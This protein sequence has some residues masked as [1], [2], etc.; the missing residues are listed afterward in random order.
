L[1]PP[2][3]AAVARRS[4]LV[5]YATATM[6]FAFL[7]FGPLI[8]VGTV[9]LLRPAPYAWLIQLPGFDR[10]RVPSRIWMLG[11]LCLAVAAG[12]GLA[13]LR[14]T[15]ARSRVLVCGLAIA[16][17]LVDGW[18]TEFPMYAV[19]SHWP[20]VERRDQPVPILELPLGPGQDAAATFR[21]MRHRRPVVN[22][23]SGYDPAFYAPLQAGLE[24]RDPEVVVALAS[25]GALDVVVDGAEDRDGRWAAYAAAIPGA[26]ATLSDGVRTVY[27]VVPTQSFDVAV[28]ES[29]PIAA[30]SVS[31]ETERAAAAIDRRMETQWENGPQQPGQWIAVDLG[32]VRDVAGVTHALGEFARDFPRALAIDASI[33]GTTWNEVLNERT[34]ALA[35]LGAIREPTAAVM[36]FSFAPRQARY[37]RLRQQ[38]SSRNLW[39]VSELQVHAPALASK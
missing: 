2:A 8:M 35:M 14:L 30:V 25:L 5:F 23:V 12:L 24:A 36:R 39:R 6:V 18:V 26:T 11:T 37:V 34:A 1:T 21:S 22:G 7:A 15:T 33:D 13:S 28:G 31:H 32:S 38:A 3:R 27:R 16:G 4:P 10:L 17:V 19:P 20:K 9:E 29:L